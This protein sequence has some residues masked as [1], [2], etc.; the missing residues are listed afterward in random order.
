M[1]K[2][3]LIA[4]IVMF[5]WWHIRRQ[6]GAGLPAVV[7]SAAAGS[8]TKVNSGPAPMMLRCAYCEMHLP[9]AEGMFDEKGQ[10]FCH[11]RHRQAYL[12]LHP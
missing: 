9:K 6:N 4:A 8:S 3:L 2:F 5:V 12:K 11:T 1:F 7:K 10:F